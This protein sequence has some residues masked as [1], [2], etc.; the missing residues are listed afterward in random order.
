MTGEMGAGEF[1]RGREDTLVREHL[2]LVHYLV[3]EMS[4]RIPSYVSRDD[5]ESAAMAGLAQ[6]ARSYEAERGVPFDRFASRRIRGALLDELRSR[7]WATRSVRASAR[8]VHQAADELSARLGRAPSS[9]ELAAHMGCDVGE[10]AS[11]AAG[12]ARANIV[13]YESLFEDGTAEN[14]L[15]EDDAA[16]PDTCLL[17][18]ERQAYLVDAVAALPARL[19]QVVMGYFFEERSMHDLA[20]ELGVTD[21]RISQMRAEALVLLREGL[22]AHLQPDAT[23][24][25]T[26]PG[27]RIARRKDAYFA[28]IG[29]RRGTLERLAGPASLADLLPA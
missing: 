6:A 2:P 5:L 21:S 23:P 27:G 4:N 18:R 16:S 14:L 28:A 11:V 13:N 10:V 3:A 17:E 7:D 12:V 8:A 29:D 24:P 19:R 15:P 26:R 22:D 20:Q 9:A 25:T 1:D